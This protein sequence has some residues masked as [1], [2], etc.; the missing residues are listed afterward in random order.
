MPESVWVRWVL[1]TTISSK[2][3]SERAASRPQTIAYPAA[4][5]RPNRRDVESLAPHAIVLFGATGDLA[6]RKLLPGL[7]AWPISRSR[8][9]RPDV[10]VVGSAMEDMSTE[11]FRAFARSATPGFGL[12]AIDDEAWAWFAERITYVPQGAGPEGLMAAVKAAENLLGAGSRRLH[13]L[14]V[15]PKR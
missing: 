5:A 14:S 3:G 8:C 9:W 4:G 13:Y 12:H 15:P 10:R 7:A 1:V 2:E 6:K 11:E